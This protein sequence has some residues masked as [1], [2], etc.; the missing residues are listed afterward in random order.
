MRTEAEM[1]SLP[2]PHHFDEPV[3]AVVVTHAKIDVRDRTVVLMAVAVVSEPPYVAAPPVDLYKL[4]AGQP[5][6]VHISGT[7]PD[8]ARLAPH[9][10]IVT[11]TGPKAIVL[12]IVKPLPVVA[13]GPD[14]YNDVITAL[15]SGVGLEVI[16]TSAHGISG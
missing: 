8:T 6:D 9:R 10:F 7:H 3:S 11:G 4:H 2:T 15:N 1:Y 5:Q 14:K 16:Y 13:I 12:R